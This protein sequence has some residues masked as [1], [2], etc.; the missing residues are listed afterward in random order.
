[1]P[2]PL[3]V[4]LVWGAWERENFPNIRRSTTS[5]GTPVDGVYLIINRAEGTVKIKVYDDK[6]SDY[7]AYRTERLVIIEEEP[8]S[9][10]AKP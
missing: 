9:R 1:M 6:R 8:W 4:D 7:A 3:D 2:S 5:S 10:R